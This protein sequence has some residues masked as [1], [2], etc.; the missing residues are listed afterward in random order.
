MAVLNF[1]YFLNKIGEKTLDAVNQV[2][3]CDTKCKKIVKKKCIHVIDCPVLRILTPRDIGNMG[4][5]GSG[6][7]KPKNKKYRK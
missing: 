1:L 6:R 3:L 4:M 2:K 5:H 7:Q